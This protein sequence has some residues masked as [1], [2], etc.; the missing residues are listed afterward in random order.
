MC[1]SRTIGGMNGLGVPARAR[2]AAPCLVLACLA[3]GL[4]LA[5]AA[6]PGTQPTS[7]P[8]TAPVELVATT[9]PVSAPT[10]DPATQPATQAAAVPDTQPASQPLV[11]AVPGD[12]FILNFKDASI[13]AVLDQLS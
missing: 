4:P 12:G 6:E 5:R 7:Q 8:A 1:G 2:A 3:V 13:D 11:V 9:Q 10:T